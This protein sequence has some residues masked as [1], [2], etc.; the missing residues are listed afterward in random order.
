MGLSKSTVNLRQSI[1]RIAPG[2]VN[3]EHGATIVY[4]ANTL[5]GFP[6]PISTLVSR[7][8]CAI[9]LLGTAQVFAQTAA[10]VDTA[11]SS[12]SA[13]SGPAGNAKS[14]H[15]MERIQALDTNKDQR[16]SRDEA[17]A[18]P[19]MAK[20]FDAVDTNKDGYL[21]RE[22][23]VAFHTARK[24][25]PHDAKMSFPITRDQAQGHEIF[26]KNFD[27]IDA[28]KDSAISKEELQ[29][30]HAAHK[31]NARAGAGAGK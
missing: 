11:A 28:N 6:M 4:A 15:M 10:A 7:S 24:A 16:I 13:A 21:T 26:A 2:N 25:M 8:V 19:R 27:V 9:A 23:M 20:H 18:N 12:A 29:A 17:N 14:G 22:E 30:F 1:Q 3:Q 5:K 31:A